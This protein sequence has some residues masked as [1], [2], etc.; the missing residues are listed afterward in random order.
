MNKFKVGDLVR[1]NL[2][3]NKGSIFWGD[4]VNGKI[5]RVKSVDDS[6]FIYYLEDGKGFGYAE[7]WLEATDTVQIFIDP[8]DPKSAHAAVSKV[9]KEW[10]D[11]QRDWTEEEIKEAKRLS[12]EM[13][14][15]L[16]HAGKSPMFSYSGCGNTV[17]FVL[18]KFG[19]WLGAYGEAYCAKVRGKDIPN[20]DIGKCVCLCKATGREIPDFIL[21]KN[22]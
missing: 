4:Q 21:R 19:M 10:K 9:C 18:M 2:P 8:S 17:S 11:K 5:Y 3:K 1:V 12:D 14:L 13:V 22:R 6:G 16:F 20:L 7:K 15:E